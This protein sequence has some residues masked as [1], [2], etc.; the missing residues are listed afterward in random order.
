M[1]SFPTR[2]R[3]SLT[4]SYDIQGC[5]D[6]TADSIT[7]DSFS[8]TK[9]CNEVDD[10]LDIELLRLGFEHCWSITDSEE[11]EYDQCNKTDW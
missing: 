10:P 8:K 6:L 9:V 3:V 2:L 7:V 1:F 4:H 11:I 5:V